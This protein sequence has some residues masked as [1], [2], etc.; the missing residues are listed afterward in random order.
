MNRYERLKKEE[1]ERIASAIPHPI[2]ICDKL[3]AE[4]LTVIDLKEL[5]KIAKCSKIEIEESW[6]E[7]CE[8]KALTIEMAKGIIERG[9]ISVSNQNDFWYHCIY[10]SSTTEEYDEKKISH[11]DWCLVTKSERFLKKDKEKL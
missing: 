1:E 2:K 11:P 5:V 6:K 10:C 9:A 3:E 7:I 8:L 4:Q